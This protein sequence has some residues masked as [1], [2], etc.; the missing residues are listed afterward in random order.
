MAENTREYILQVLQEDLSINIPPEE[1]VR[2][3]D[4]S[5]INA[6]EMR[7]RI[8]QEAPGIVVPPGG[9]VG[10]IIYSTRE[11][12]ARIMASIIDEGCELGP[13]K[14]CTPEEAEERRLER[15]PESA[16]VVS[17]IRGLGR[18]VHVGAGAVRIAKRDK[19]I[20]LDTPVGLVKLPVLDKLYLSRRRVGRRVTSGLMPS[21]MEKPYDQVIVPRLALGRAIYIDYPKGVMEI[22]GTTDLNCW[23]GNDI[24]SYLRVVSDKA[25]GMKIDFWYTDTISQIMVVP[26]KAWES[27]AIL[28][29][30][31][32]VVW[33]QVLESRGV[34]ATSFPCWNSS[35]SSRCLGTL[36]RE[37]YQGAG[38]SGTTD[39]WW[40]PRTNM[41]A[42]RYNQALI[43]VLMQES[44]FSNEMVAPNIAKMYL[45]KRY[46]EQLLSKLIEATKDKKLSGEDKITLANRVCLYH[47][48]HL[49]CDYDI[50]NEGA[51]VIPLR[52]IPTMDNNN[53]RTWE[54]KAKY[55][56][57]CFKSRRDS[58]IS[59]LEIRWILK[60]RG[61]VRSS[62][63]L[64]K[65]IAHRV[66]KAEVGYR[67]D[68]SIAHLYAY[69]IWAS[70][71]KGKEGLIGT[72]L[73]SF[74]ECSDPTRV[75]AYAKDYYLEASNI[76]EKAMLIPPR[77]IRGGAP[78]A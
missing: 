62:Y 78:N 69:Q 23:N 1:V 28:A 47:V 33:P 2:Q 12:E 26:H 10:R 44:T 13:P 36:H 20:R 48:G 68:Y 70:A 74:R 72:T 50:P 51:D 58:D 53:V 61:F 19:K 39:S 17:H 16:Y 63:D 3:I 59:A 14:P 37:D 49:A 55:K 75:A 42:T 54:V 71:Y 31:D 18:P 27:L 29:E 77:I 40:S 34:K 67:V 25:L 64:S 46:T 7:E 15:H 56:G 76:T 32:V 66:V 45:P 43:A 41:G 22:A 21:D 9:P 4:G 52:V 60:D 73:I 11:V 6:V 8:T 5:Q 65:A 57:V 24:S 38:Y 35:G 30:R